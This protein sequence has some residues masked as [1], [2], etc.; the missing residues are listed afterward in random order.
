MGKLMSAII[1]LGV[2]DAEGRGNLISII[3][4]LKKGGGIERKVRREFK[5]V[6]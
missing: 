2:V 4:I 6:S 5:I 3:E 1:T